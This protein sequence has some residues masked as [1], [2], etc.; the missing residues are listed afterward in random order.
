M[1]C[2]YVQCCV[3]YGPVGPLMLENPL[4]NIS[5]NYICSKSFLLRAGVIRLPALQCV[6]F[7]NLLEIFSA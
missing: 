7:E 5:T 3:V 4:E 2:T 1:Y 6:V